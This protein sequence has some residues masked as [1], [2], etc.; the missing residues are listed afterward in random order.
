MNLEKNIKGLSNLLKNYEIILRSAK[1][2]EVVQSLRKLYGQHR[3]PLKLLTKTF[4][5]S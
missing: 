4:K 2:V 3:N 1:T 5:I